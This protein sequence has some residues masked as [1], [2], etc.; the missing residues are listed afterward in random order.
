MAA[1]TRSRK[2]TSTEV[3]KQETPQVPDLYRPPALDIGAGDIALPRLYR[4]ESSSPHVKE[5]NAPVGS[6]FLASG[7]DDPA[8][9]VL[10]KKGEEVG[11]LFSVLSLSKYRS[12]F[13]DGQSER[14][15]VNDPEA[16]EDSW[17]VYDY[18]LALPGSTDLPVR[19]ALTRSNTPTAKQVNVVL[20]KQMAERPPYSIGFRLTTRSKSNNKGSWFVFQAVPAEMTDEQIQQAASLAEMVANQPEPQPAA[21]DAPA[22]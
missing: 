20:A 14:W 3:A 18:T 7:K 1:A 22:I 16:P 17:I 21:S 4:G 19:W 6:I 10:W 9:E 12:I 13:E 15:D 11:V 2:K 5:G 8:P